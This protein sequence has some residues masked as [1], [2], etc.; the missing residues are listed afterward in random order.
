MKRSGA[1]RGSLKALARFVRVFRPYVLAQWPLIGLG[2][3]GLLGSAL[4]RLLE[5]WPLKFVIDRITGTGAERARV[6][7]D[8]VNA[9]DTQSLLLAAA[10][11]LV[12]IATL[13]A[14]SSYVSTIG[15][16]L[17]GNRTLTQVRAALFRHLQNLSLRFHGRSRGGDVVVRMI[18]DV[19]MVQEVTVTAVLPMLGNALVLVGMFAV[20]FWLE[21]VLAAIAACTL[22]LMAIATLRRGRTIRHAA[23][24]TRRQEGALAATASES[25]AAIKTVQS[26][27]LGE[28]F[29]GAFSRQNDAN[30][31]EGVRVKRLSAGLERGMDILI[32][33]ATAAVLWVGAVR[34]L[35]GQLS[36]GE[37]LVF[38]F[39][40]KG[41]FRPLR[42]FAKYGARLAKASAA[43]DRIVELFEQRADVTESPQAYPL[44]Y[45]P[46]EIRFDHVGFAYE[47]D[48]TVLHEITLDIHAGTHV[49]IVGPS[50]SGKSTLAALVLRL[51]DPDTGQV[52]IDGHD[53]R[54][55]SIDSLRGRIGTVLQDTVLFAGTIRDNIAFGLDQVTD[56]QVE[57]AARLANAHEFI[58]RLPAGYNTPVDERGVN[59]SNGQRQRIAIARAAIR[60]MP[61]LL[62]DEPTTGLDPVNEAQVLDALVKLSRGRTTLHITHR[63]EAARYADRIIVLRGGR[64]IEDGSHTGLI[65]AGG[66]YASRTNYSKQ[67]AETAH[68][69]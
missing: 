59:L 18:G 30:L 67:Q 36:A 29:A 9:L 68:V 53:L 16:A 19:G 51:F 2:L 13:R 46:G 25:F 44:P 35:D 45:G 14:G 22:P 56:E 69:D 54:G 20:M 34:V 48:R 31:G 33:L 5:P 63:P 49:A 1:F 39:Y 52:L 3:I 58:E 21:P 11:G 12:A 24:R 57:S 60:D 43:A 55:V 4:M 17:A 10:V 15:F 62:L 50:G 37:L 8:A 7:I 47:Q 27:S 6:S 38:L 65:A 41:A 23:R 26:L 40:L 28:R 42:D 64:V 66:Y 32:A 61:I